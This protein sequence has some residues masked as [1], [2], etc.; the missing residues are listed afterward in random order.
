MLEIKSIFCIE[1]LMASGSVDI[2]PESC[3]EKVADNIGQAQARNF[4]RW[5]IFGWHVSVALINLGSWEKEVE[6]VHDF[7]A[8]R[9]TWLDDKLK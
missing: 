5:Q 2:I 8:D 4:Q 7:F 3:R 1:Y 9:V 6:Y